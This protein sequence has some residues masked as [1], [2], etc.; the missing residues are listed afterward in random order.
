MLTPPYSSIMDTFETALSLVDGAEGHLIIAG[1]DVEQLAE[2]SDFEGVC[3]LLLGGQPPEWRGALGRGRV[4]AFAALPRLGDALARADG[5]DA[6]RAGLAHLETEEPGVAIGALATL[7]AA[8]MRFRRGE[9]PV[10]PDPES[11]HA[12]DYLRMA[13]SLGGDGDAAA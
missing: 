10:A 1:H 11:G 6:L 5:M 2:R 7:A 3:A 4:Q 13:L 8:W 12:E 9:A